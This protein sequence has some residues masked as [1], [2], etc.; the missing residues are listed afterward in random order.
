MRAPSLNRRHLV[1]AGAAWLAGCATPAQQTPL[2]PLR[3]ADFLAADWRAAQRLMAAASDDNTAWRLVQALCTQVGARPAG[4]SADA[5]A[6]SWALSALQGLGLANGR[7]EAL[8]MKAWVRGPASA[9]LLG[10]QPQDPMHHLVMAALGNSVAAPAAGIEADVAWYPTLQAL[11]DDR[12]D[13]ARGRIVFIDQK[14]QRTRDGRGYGLAV[15]ARLNGAVEAARRGALAV[16]IRSIGTDSERI[17]HTGAMRYRVDVPAIP[18]FAV[19]VPDAEL[20]ATR[21]AQG[22]TLRLRLKLQAHSGVDATTHNVIAELP[23]SDLAHEIVLIGAHLDSWDLGL[24][25]IDDGAGVAIVSAAAGLMQRLGLQPRRTVR[26]VLFGNEE[27][28]FDGARAYGD[29]YGTVPHQWVG[30]SDFGAGRVW[31]M[32]CR[33]Q[34]DALPLVQRMARLLSP[35]GVAWATDRLNQGSPGPDAGVLMRR[36]KWPAV[37]LSQDGTNYF[38]VHHTVH[39]TLDRIDPATLPQ[40]V[41]CWAVT[42]WLAAQS[43]VSFGP[44]VV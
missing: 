40:N 8:P 30:E 24:G 16:G 25:A 43:P 35:L 29:R 27:N 14:T 11:Q 28:G 13:R 7:A 44:V 1:G 3:S 21:Q 41:A 17:A 12:S 6:V 20:M 15:V 18:A 32:N 42:A 38:D 2:L 5:R 23:G 9:V 22:Q 4:S 33:V 37:Q 26:V 36:H 34:P 39:D 10:P 19:S 31:Q